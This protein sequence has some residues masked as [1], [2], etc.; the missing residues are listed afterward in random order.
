MN[1]L[2]A[3]HLDAIRALARK[4]G[5]RRLEL[6]GFAASDAFDPATSAVDFLVE[7][8]SRTTPSALG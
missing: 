3:H 4:Y 8:P 1:Q 2:S 5:V 7:H 6:F